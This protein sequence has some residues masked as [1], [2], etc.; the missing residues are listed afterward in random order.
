MQTKKTTVMGRPRV[1]TPEPQKHARPQALVF[2]PR[3]I[4]RLSR[5]VNDNPEK[6]RGRSDESHVVRVKPHEETLQTFKMILFFPHKFSRFSISGN[7]EV[8]R[9]THPK[10]D[11]HLKIYNLLLLFIFITFFSKLIMGIY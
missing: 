9:K 5:T 8:S 4:R 3:G 6:L 7:L 1:G 2:F 11:F 10:N